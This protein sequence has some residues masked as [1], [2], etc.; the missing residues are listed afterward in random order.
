MPAARRRELAPTAADPARLNHPAA[1]RGSGSTR[2]GL[3][4]AL[5]TGTHDVPVS[6]LDCARDVSGRLLSFPGGM[7]GSAQCSITS[8]K[9]GESQ[10]LTL[11]FGSSREKSKARPVG[12]EPTTFGFEV[13]DSIR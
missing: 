11:P 2:R 7:T 12:F 9:P 5:K 10:D 8:H 3:A 1:A 13:R 6:R 4:A